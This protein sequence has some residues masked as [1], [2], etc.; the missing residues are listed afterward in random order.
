MENIARKILGNYKTLIK[1]FVIK[2]YL[3]ELFI[4]SVFCYYLLLSQSDHFTNFVCLTIQ[5]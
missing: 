3:N 2:V 1:E 5:N 4:T